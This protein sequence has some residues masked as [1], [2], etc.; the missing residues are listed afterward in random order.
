LSDKERKFFVFFQNSAI[1]EFETADLSGHIALSSLSLL[2][3]SEEYF[4]YTGKNFLIF[5]FNT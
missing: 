4:G 1:A 3:A 5:K 2:T